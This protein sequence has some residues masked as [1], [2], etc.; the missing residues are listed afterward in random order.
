MFSADVCK[1]LCLHDGLL[2]F[3]PYSFWLRQSAAFA[4]YLEH[5]PV[6]RYS[7]LGVPPLSFGV[8]DIVKICALSTSS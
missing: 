6:L 8:Y 5:R 3:A 1:L 4:F 2:F 7:L